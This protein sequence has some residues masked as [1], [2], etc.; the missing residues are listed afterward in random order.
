MWFIRAIVEPVE[1]NYL[2]KETNSLQCRSDPTSCGRHGWVRVNS[3]LA[4]RGPSLQVFIGVASWYRHASCLP[5]SPVRRSCAGGVCRDRTLPSLD[6]R[7]HGW[8]YIDSISAVFQSKCSW[9]FRVSNYITWSGV[10]AYSVSRTTSSYPSKSLYTVTSKNRC[11]PFLK[12]TLSN[13]FA[14]KSHS[15]P[16]LA[17]CECY[18]WVDLFLV[19]WCIFG[20]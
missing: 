7:K 10:L 6:S 20:H 11:W 14:D 17:Q 12:K 19:S 1:E 4:A 13:N 15:A 3:G 9:P 8:I 2:E 16:T 18:V 5:S